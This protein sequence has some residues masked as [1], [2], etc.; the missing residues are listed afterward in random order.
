MADGT[1]DPLVGLAALD[2]I[3]DPAFRRIVH[4]L[5]PADRYYTE[6]VKAEHVDDELLRRE[7]RDTASLPTVLQLWGNNPQAYAEAARRVRTLSRQGGPEPPGAGNSFIG[8]EINLG[9]AVPKMLRKGYCAALMKR[10]DLVREIVRT[11]RHAAP[12]MRLSIK[13]RLADEEETTQWWFGFL[14]QLPIDGVAV[15]FRRMSE[16]Y[17]RPAS[18]RGAVELVRP[19]RERG[20]E[21]LGN[22]DL[23]GRSEAE[24]SAAA[25]GLDGALIGRAITHSP[26]VFRSKFTSDHVGPRSWFAL[27]VHRRLQLF[28]RH[29]RDHWALYGAAAFPRLKRF[30]GLYLPHG[31]D[32]ASAEAQLVPAVLGARSHPEALAFL[33]H[34]EVAFTSND[35][36]ER[37]PTET[38]GVSLG[39]SPAPESGSIR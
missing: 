26:L 3:T 8:I 24:A 28:R 15:H 35:T 27:P 13:T 1:H 38:D 21:V 32:P 29:I 36:E 16:G 37:K 23:S 18:W 20:I 9:C 5:G 25:Q 39:L 33:Q 17:R 10:P 12:Q 30:A 7:L 31:A 34:A 19:L 22:G 14:A 11:L 2:G 6:F 4:E